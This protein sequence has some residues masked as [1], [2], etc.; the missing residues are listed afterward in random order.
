MTKSK[1][2]NVMF[3]LIASCRKT[4]S[5]QKVIAIKKTHQIMLESVAEE[6]AY[7]TM[8]CPVTGAKFH[9]SDI[10]P[11]AQV[12]SGFASSGKVEAKKY[13]PSMN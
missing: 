7:P 1:Y 10:V 3:A 12:A 2:N 11:M 6:L 8:T 4:I 13:R 5:S 9:K